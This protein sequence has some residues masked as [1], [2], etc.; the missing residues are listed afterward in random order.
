MR[1]PVALGAL[2]CLVAVLAGCG[3]GSSDS[4]SS[5]YSVAKTRACLVSKKV[6]L[7]GQLDFVASTATG[8]ALRARLPDNVVTIAFGRTLADARNIAQAYV[9]FHAKN[10]GI[11]DVL[12]TQGNAVMLWHAHPLDADLSLIQDCLTT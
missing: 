5:V 7:G 9:H 10:V 11:T 8:G 3:G 1:R 6:R 2:A 4:A 12:R